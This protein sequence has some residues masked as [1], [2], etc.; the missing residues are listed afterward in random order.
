MCSSVE[1]SVGW[2]VGQM[3]NI[4]SGCCLLISVFTDLLQNTALAIPLSL[5]MQG[6]RVMNSVVF[7]SARGQSMFSYFI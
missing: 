3:V 4:C 1:C 2:W 6:S 7:Y 5:V